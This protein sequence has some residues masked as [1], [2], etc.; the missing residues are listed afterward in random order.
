MHSIKRISGQMLREKM[1]ESVESGMIE[2][3]SEL[4]GKKDIMSILVRART[5]EVGSGY[6]MSDEAMMAQVLTFLGAGHETTASGLT[7]TLWLLANDIPSQDKLRAEVSPVYAKTSRP[8][9]KTLR[10]MKWL[11]CVVMESLRVMPPVPIT[12]RRASKS[13]Y[14]DGLFVPKGTLFWIPIRT[15]NTWQTAWGDDAEEFHPERW[16]NL[17][18]SYNSAFSTFSF[19]AGPHMCIGKT[20]AITEMKAVLAALI[21][22]FSFE[23]AYKGQKALTAAAITMKPTDGMPLIVKRVVQD[24]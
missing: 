1:K 12:L 16:L 5:R 22:N 23:P 20:M 8:D 14:I 15:I 13:D 3:D 10:D 19:I 9:Y 4:S 24:Q 21:A 2:G 6:K 7:W 18:K 11:D 17:P